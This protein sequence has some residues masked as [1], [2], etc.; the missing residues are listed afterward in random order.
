MLANIPMF[1][2]LV[3][4]TAYI[5]LSGAD[6][7]AGFWALV[8][9]GR[10]PPES[11]EI[12]NYLHRAMGPVW[13]ANH[14]WLIFILVIC[15]TAYPIAFASITSTLVV[16]LFISAVGIILRGTSYALRGQ[17]DSMPAE[18]LID[19]RVFAISSIMTPFAL[20]AAIGGIASGRVPVGNATGNLITSWLNPTSVLIGILSVATSSHLAAV[21]LAADACRSGAEL[22]VGAFRS[23]ALWSGLAAGALSM[24]ALLVLRADSPQIWNGLTGGKE[25]FLLGLS[26]ASGL[27]TLVLVWRHRFGSARVAAGLAVVAI[28]AGWAEAQQPRFLPG[29][30]VSEAAAE[31]STLTAVILA[32][33]F[34]AVV[35]VPSLGLLLDLVL[36]GRLDSSPDGDTPDLNVSSTPPRRRMRLAGFV[37]ATFLLGTGGTV[38]GSGWVQAVG[39]VCLCA[40]AGSTFVLVATDDIR[41]N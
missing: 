19:D 5:V 25:I 7:G 10:R 21:Y 32:V 12:R 26:G 35:L 9:G 4:L 36:S 31:R 3:G 34:G 6:F 29:L 28:V 14:V 8:P 37:L 39:I 20:G 2:I 38:L 13:E 11:L 17:F 22:L 27:A 1:F 18:R 15:W 16:P 30:T 23:R 24:I 40:F 33:A 41:S